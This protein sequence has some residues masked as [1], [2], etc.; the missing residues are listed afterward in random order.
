[1]MDVGI[2]RKKGRTRK[3]KEAKAKAYKLVNEVRSNQII[4]E[5]DYM[6][7]SVKEKMRYANKLEQNIRLL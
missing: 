7:G 4:V 5:T 3:G 2:G 6:D 1:M